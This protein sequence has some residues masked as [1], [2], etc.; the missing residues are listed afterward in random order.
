[1]LIDYYPQ[2]PGPGLEVIRN[3][4]YPVEL[5]PLIV[6]RNPAS[7]SGLARATTAST[8]DAGWIERARTALQ[9][10]AGRGMPAAQTA[11]RFNLEDASQ[12]VGVSVADLRELATRGQ[13]TETWEVGSDGSREQ[14]IRADDLARLLG[15]S[16][17]PMQVQAR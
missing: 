9:R 5:R 13:I 4:K 7:R 6:G 15:R 1:V 17:S 14:R 10:F 8:R 2:L 16:G 3:P 11:P 12:I